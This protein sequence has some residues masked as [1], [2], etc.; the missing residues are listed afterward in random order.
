[1][2]LSKSNSTDGE[3]KRFGGHNPG[4]EGLSETLGGD[5]ER[6]RR[7]F[8]SA[9]EGIV[10]TSPAGE[11]LDCNPFLSQL[12][13]YTREELVG[14]QASRLYDQEAREELFDPSRIPAR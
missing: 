3:H 6:Y 7:L 4:T 12:T 8:E 9:Q 11:I 5:K 14:M 1:M 2:T 13:G 10:L